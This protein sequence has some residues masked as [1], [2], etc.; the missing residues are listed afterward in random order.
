MAGQASNKPPKKVV[1]MCRALEADPA[2][3]HDDVDE[4]ALLDFKVYTDKVAVV[5]ATGQKYTLSY[6]A[7]AERIKAL[8]GS[9]GLGKGKDKSPADK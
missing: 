3:E 5:I 2:C 6:A 7:I 1:D 8:A 4:K 9:K